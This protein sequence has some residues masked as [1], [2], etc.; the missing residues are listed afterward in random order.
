MGILSKIFG[1]ASTEAYLL[2]HVAGQNPADRMSPGDIIQALIKLSSFSR[3]ED[4]GISVMVE[5]RALRDVPEG[6]DFKGIPVTY[7]E[8]DKPAASLASNAIR[9]ARR[10]GRLVVVTTNKD[11]ENIALREGVEILNTATLLRAIETS[12][13]G[14]ERSSEGRG[15]GGDRRNRG[16]NR[17]R[18]PRGRGGRGDG[19][20]GEGRGDNRDR[21]DDSSGNQ[22]SGGN[23][24]VNQ[25]IDVVE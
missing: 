22:N 5:G 8:G 24:G 15:D 12:L 1:T 20:G 11:L 16:R 4:I 2:V 25:L 18:G 14:G 23:S 17:R 3:N 6:Q 9:R 13:E 7:L 10:N 19:R 21:R